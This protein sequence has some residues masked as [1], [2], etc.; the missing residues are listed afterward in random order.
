MLY[1]WTFWA[2]VAQTIDFRPHVGI[3]LTRQGWCLGWHRQE[4][5]LF[6]YTIDSLRVQTVFKNNITNLH[7]NAPNRCQSTFDLLPVF[8]SDCF[9]NHC[10]SLSAT[11]SSADQLSQKFKRFF[12]LLSNQSPFF[13]SPSCIVSC[14][15]MQ[16]SWS[17]LTLINN[18]RFQ[19]YFWVKKMVNN[20]RN[21]SL[22]CVF[23]QG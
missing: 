17:P 9:P 22:K 19:S 5:W 7:L 4:Q 21:K 11:N 20:A 15:R 1:T 12:S 8:S 23:Q 18:A 6:S 2:S 14:S 10:R 16:L 13:Y 3:N